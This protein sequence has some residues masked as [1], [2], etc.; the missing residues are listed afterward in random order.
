MTYGAIFVNEKI[1]YTAPKTS[2]KIKINI[3]HAIPVNT[4]VAKDNPL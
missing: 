3:G 1:S 2:A 4:I